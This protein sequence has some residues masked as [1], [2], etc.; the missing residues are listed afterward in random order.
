VWS[1]SE[2]INEEFARYFIPANVQVDAPT[3]HALSF[4]LRSLSAQS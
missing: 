3:V 1:T 2:T 4:L